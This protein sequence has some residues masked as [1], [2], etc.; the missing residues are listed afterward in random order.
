MDKYILKLYITG[1]TS[2]SERAINNIKKICEGELEGQFKIEVIDI[3][4]DPKLAE[5]EKILAT[6]TL[7][8]TLPSPIRRIIGDLSDMEKVLIGL[9]LVGIST[10]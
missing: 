5:D 8:K 2:K 7:V 9:N 4:E 1:Q 3:L 10:R 6:P